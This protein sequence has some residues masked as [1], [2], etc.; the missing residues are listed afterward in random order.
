MNWGKIAELFTGE[1]KY[2]FWVAV[3]LAVE[4]PIMLIWA[5]YKRLRRPSREIRFARLGRLQF[6]H[7]A[8]RLSIYTFNLIFF[9]IMCFGSYAF[10][11]GGGLSKDIAFTPLTVIGAAVTFVS[12]VFA[13]L[14]FIKFFRA[15]IEIYERGFVINTGITSYPVLYSDIRKVE[16]YLQKASVFFFSHYKTGVLAFYDKNG[17]F[18]AQADSA[19]FRINTNIAQ[20]FAKINLNN[21]DLNHNVEPERYAGP[22]GDGQYSGSYSGAQYSG[23]AEDDETVSPLVRRMVVTVFDKTNWE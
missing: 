23:T 21:N 1:Y 16:W 5:G 17:N 2:I 7:S 12:G 15:R 3:F 20:R 4:I 19:T 8:K 10:S 22:Y 18:L 11:A 9:I 6:T 14:W 13:V